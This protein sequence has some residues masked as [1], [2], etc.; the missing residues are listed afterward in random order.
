[1]NLGNIVTKSPVTVP[2]EFNIFDSIE[3]I[4]GNIPTLIVGWDLAERLFPNQDITDKKITKLIWWT[5]NRSERKDEHTIGVY[6][7]IEHAYKEMVSNINYVFV[8]YINFSH[9]KLNKTLSKINSL[10]DFISYQHGNMIYMYSH[11]LIFGMDL[12]LLKYMGYN[13][14]KCISDIKEFSTEY[15]TKE[16]IYDVYLP[17]IERVD[18]QVKY[19]PY[20]LLFH[21]LLI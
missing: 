17:H 15:L 12:S 5:F 20:L 13:P 14:E 19:I 8:D 10:H 3:D 11:K 16:E 7:F 9:S 1:M 21:V 2:N 6:E 18:N 4:D